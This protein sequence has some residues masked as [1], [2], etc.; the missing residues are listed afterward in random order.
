MTPS[1][2]LLLVSM[3]CVLVCHSDEHWYVPALHVSQCLACPIASRVP[4][5]RVYLNRMSRQDNGPGMSSQRVANQ[6]TT[7]LLQGCR[8]TIDLVFS[9]NF[10]RYFVK[11]VIELWKS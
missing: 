11:H 4:V 1:C 3:S 6:N 5:S 9:Y 8:F 7:D 2:L 10:Y